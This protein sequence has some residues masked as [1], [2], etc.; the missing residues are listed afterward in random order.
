MP[1]TGEVDV[2][3][4]WRALPKNIPIVTS[5]GA[6]R[7]GEKE[8]LMC[9]RDPWIRVVDGLLAGG[10]FRIAESHYNG[11]TVVLA[12]RGILEVQ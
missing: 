10:N 11:T 2:T 12:I 5:F 7:R 4:D 6:S 9:V 3:F 8:R 1:R